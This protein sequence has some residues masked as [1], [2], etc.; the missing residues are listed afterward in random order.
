LNA[1]TLSFESS[2]EWV[3]AYASEMKSFINDKGLKGKERIKCMQELEEK[4]ADG[5][6]AIPDGAAKQLHEKR[7]K[8]EK[9]IG[10]K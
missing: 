1:R 9:R 8:A 4:N 7:L 6:S 2:T 10:E 3:D 5:L